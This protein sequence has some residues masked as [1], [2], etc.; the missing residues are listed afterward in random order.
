MLTLPL[1]ETWLDIFLEKFVHIEWQ[2]P[3]HVALQNV[4]Y[5]YIKVLGQ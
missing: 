1:R 4:Q 2:S 5:Y 3:I